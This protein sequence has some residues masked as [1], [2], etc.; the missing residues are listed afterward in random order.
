MHRYGPHLFHTNN[1]PVVDW[2]RRFGTFVPYEH[3]VTVK[4]G[5]RFHSLPVSRATFESF[6][7]TH[8]SSDQDFAD[9]VARKRIPNASPENAADYLHALIGQE[10]T[11]L[12]FRPYTKKM[13]GHA[14]EDMDAAVVK[15]LSIKTGY[16]RRYFPDDE[17]QILPANGYTSLFENIFDHDSIQVDVSTP[18]ERGMIADVDHVFTAAS[19]DEYFDFRFGELPYRS[20]RFHQERLEAAAVHPPTSV[21]NYSD[22]G[23]YTRE[24]YWHLLP[25][26]HVRDTG[27]VI[28]SIE[29]PCD[30]KS[31]AMERYYP[32][33]D[34]AGVNQER[35]RAYKALADDESK[36]DFI[37]RCGTYKYLDMHQV[38]NQSM[39]GASRWL[40]DQCGDAS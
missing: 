15:R 38:I 33:A 32:I 24:T 4:H 20:I 39:I 31:N 14:L 34:A 8:F 22:D 6:F 35:Y 11:D 23:P 7:E 28:R 13:W 37:G 26:H 18:F 1:R 27:T 21:V 3:E 40:Q 19:I 10:L 25:G 12:I 17:Y 36:V 5:E 30:Y 9:F 16:E 29:E 2:L